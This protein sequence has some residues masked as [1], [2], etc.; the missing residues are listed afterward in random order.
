LAQKRT[1]D[2]L[3]DDERSLLRGDIDDA[4]FRQ[5]SWAMFSPTELLKLYLRDAF[6]REGVPAAETTNLR[7]WERER[8]DLGRNVL[9]IL[10]ATDSGTFQLDQEV[11]SLTESSSKSIIKAIRLNLLRMLI[12]S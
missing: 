2:A 5:D 1:S 3:T 10:R 11:N 7:T 12:R 8:L 6:N 9:N 4:F